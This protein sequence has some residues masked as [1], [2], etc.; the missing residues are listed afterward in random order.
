MGLVVSPAVADFWERLLHVPS[1][2]KE[3]SE[4][5]KN[6]EIYKKNIKIYN[7]YTVRTKHVKMNLS[8]A[9]FIKVC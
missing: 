4:Y 6:I 7:L 5:R 8:Q 3:C 2:G 1:C 9:L